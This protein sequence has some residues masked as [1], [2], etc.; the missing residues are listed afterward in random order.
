[1][2]NVVHIYHKDLDFSHGKWLVLTTANY[3]LNSVG[4]ILDEKGLYW[5]RRNSTPR[6]KNIYDSCIQKWEL[7]YVQGTPLHYNDIK[8]IKAKMNNG[9]WDKKLF[10]DLAKDGFYDIDTLKDKFGLNTEV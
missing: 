3:M 4:E 6:V 7:N 10:K 9:T 1:M 2:L 8:K 5:Q